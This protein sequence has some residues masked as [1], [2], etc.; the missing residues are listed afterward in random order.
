MISTHIWNKIIPPHLYYVTTV[1]CKIWASAVLKKL[2]IL[3]L[4][5]FS[6]DEK[7]VTVI[8]IGSC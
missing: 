7:D 6:S 8:W 1:P 5:L 4:F 2:A 3:Y